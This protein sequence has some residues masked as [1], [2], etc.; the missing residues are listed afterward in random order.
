MKKPNSIK[1]KAGSQ[2]VLGAPGTGKTTYCLAEVEQALRK[3]SRPDKI[4]YVS[5]TKKA[6][7]EA[8]QRATQTLNIE[9]DDL[10]YFRTLHSLALYTSGVRGS[11]LMNK[12]NYA[13]LSELLGE[14]IQ[15]N[16]NVDYDGLPTRI[17]KA[18]SSALFLDNLSRLTRRPL[19]D[20]YHDLPAEDRHSWLAVQQAQQIYTQYRIDSGAIDFTDL[21]ELALKTCEP[22]DLDLAIVDEAQDLSLLQW[23]VVNKLLHRAKRL[24]IAGD[25]DQAIYNWAGASIDMF[26]S[27]EGEVKHLP[28][29]YRL[30]K[31]VYNLANDVAS[32]I[33][34]RR[35]K[36]YVSR[37]IEGKIERHRTIRAI[38]IDPKQ[39]WLLLARHRKDVLGFEKY[40]KHAA[41]PYLKQS[42]KSSVDPVDLMAIMAYEELLKHK[43]TSSYKR[44][45]LKTVAPWLFEEGNADLKPSYTKEYKPWY[46]VLN[47]AFG[48]ETT[49]YYRGIKRR[50]YSL[51]ETPTIR[52]S[53]IHGVKGGEADNVIISSALNKKT[54]W[55]YRNKSDTEHRVFYVGITRAKK[56]L[57]ILEGAYR[58]SYMI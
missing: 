23:L 5:F 36:Q 19:L 51:T 43:E 11:Y 9:A 25:D 46:N 15:P 41:L 57:H 45:C 38:E 54:E 27:I 52:I 58:Y 18:A 37:D 24:I 49:E 20:L 34:K 1:L 7:Q 31:S 47:K 29:S 42:G 14:K 56:E 40:L 22:L 55:S 48:Y 13:D 8:I 35:P 53:T 2:L 16:N 28:V 44:K 32:R 30:P 26:L 4:A 21:L 17:N 12:Q 50:G 33:S 10:P 6:I 3:G 39:T